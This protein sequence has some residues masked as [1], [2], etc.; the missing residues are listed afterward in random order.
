MTNGMN[1]DFE[2]RTCFANFDG[3]ETSIPAPNPRSK[4]EE[5][6]QRQAIACRPEASISENSEEQDKQNW[7]GEKKTVRGTRPTA[8]DPHG[9][10]RNGCC[11]DGHRPN[12]TRTSRTR[13]NCS[14]VGC[15][16]SRDRSATSTA[17]VTSAA[18]R[19]HSC[20]RETG[21]DDDNTASD[22]RRA[23]K[24]LAKRHSAP[25]PA[26]YA[27]TDIVPCAPS[28]AGR[29][30]RSPPHV[31]EIRIRMRMRT[32]GCLQQRFYSFFFFIV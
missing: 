16:D 12:V 14:C 18:N 8:A 1:T 20:C 29:R 24:W 7:R 26:N 22:R 15:A 9:T 19:H 11:G 2:L 3:N 27:V 30:G 5:Q 21:Y 25:G 28:V 4:N 13:Y 10:R 23:N 6:Q 17:A 31:F 32:R